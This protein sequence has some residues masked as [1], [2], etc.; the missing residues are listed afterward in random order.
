VVADTACRVFCVMLTSPPQVKYVIREHCGRA[1]HLTDLDS[2]EASFSI[3]CRAC[4]KHVKDYKVKAKGWEIADCGKGMACPECGDGVYISAEFK[5]ATLSKAA[6][7]VGTGLVGATVYASISGAGQVSVST[8]R[9]KFLA[10]C[11]KN[12]ESIVRRRSSG[13]GLTHAR[14]LESGARAAGGSADLLFPRNWT[15]KGA[16][17]GSERDQP[18]AWWGAPQF[19]QVTEG[20]HEWSEVKHR[21]QSSIP[22]ARLV[23]LVRWEDRFMWKKFHTRREEVFV[24]REMDESKLNEKFLWHGTGGKSPDEVLKTE[25]GLDFRFSSQDCFYGRG[26]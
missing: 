15:V 20:S 21:L 11:N 17:V 14:M 9:K 2:I 25:E 7:L 23:D 8:S 22:H 10:D 12:K 6:V 13:S 26:L 24:R 16:P 19:V 1:L 4:D 3:L 18:A 5:S